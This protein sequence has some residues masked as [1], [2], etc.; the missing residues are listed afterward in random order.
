MNEL[1]ERFP[2][3]L[4]Y[5]VSLDTTLPVSEGFTSAQATA[6]STTAGST[7]AATV[8]SFGNPRRGCALASGSWGRDPAALLSCCPLIDTPSPCRR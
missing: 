6:G 1:S 5:G 8:S 7:A 4:E 2:N 3:D